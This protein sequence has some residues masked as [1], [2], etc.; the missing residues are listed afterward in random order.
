MDY[1]SLFATE[2]DFMVLG[3]RGVLKGEGGG[4]IR[5]VEN[6]SVL[7]EAKRPLAVIFMN[8]LFIILLLKRKKKRTFL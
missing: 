3:G 1:K 6:G 2:E 4:L 7:S 5:A 8:V